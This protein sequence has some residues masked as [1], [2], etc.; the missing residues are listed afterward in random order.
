MKNR[1]GF[2]PQMRDYDHMGFSWHPYVMF[3]N[4]KNYKSEYI[5]IDAKGTRITHNDFPLEV[6]NLFVGGSTAFG[7]GASDDKYTIPSLLSGSWSN[8][9]GRAY[10]S[11]QEL[12][13][14]MFN[15]YKFSKIK[16]VV[17]FSGLNNLIFYYLSNEYDETYGTT[18]YHDTYLTKMENISKKTWLKN[19]ISPKKKIEKPDKS[20][21]IYLLRRDIAWWKR[22]SKALDFELHYFLQPFFNWTMKEKCYEEEILFRELDNKSKQWQILSKELDGDYIWF[23]DSI[24]DICVDNE[25]PFTDMNEMFLKYGM[26]AWLWADRVHLTDAGNEIMAEEV[27][28]NIR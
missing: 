13:F 27:E 5:N 12:L 17:I 9:G 14:F 26:D 10:F 20:V 16:K 23:S 7:V 6:D 25:I 8:L 19:L 28:R 4:K 24:R 2:L 21:V 15:Q 22:L 1:Y 18:Y 3:V 11:T